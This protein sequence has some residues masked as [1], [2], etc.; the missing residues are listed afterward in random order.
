ML[1]YPK[2][3]REAAAA[4]AKKNMC[5]EKLSRQQL[6]CLVAYG[7]HGDLPES[8]YED[9]VAVCASNV[10]YFPPQKV[11]V[12]DLVLALKN[13]IKIPRKMMP[14][15]CLHKRS[16]L[17]TGD[18]EV[19]QALLASGAV[20]ESEVV[21]LVQRGCVSAVLALTCAPW[22][23]SRR[24]HLTRTEIETV[25]RAID[26]SLVNDMIPKL[27]ICSQD[28][29]ALADTVGIPPLNKALGEIDDA[30]TCARLVCDWP[31]LN[32]MKFLSA[33]MVRSKEFARAVRENAMALR[34]R[35]VG[36][37]R[38]VGI[39]KF[40][41][42]M[43]PEE[44]TNFHY[45]EDSAAANFCSAAR[46]FKT[47][48]SAKSCVPDES[49]E[50]D[51]E[52]CNSI[53]PL[54]RRQSL[55]SPR[56]SARSSASS[57]RARCAS[58][59]VT[60]TPLASAAG[61]TPKAKLASATDTAEELL[62]H[63][64]DEWAQG[65]RAKTAALEKMLADFRLN[66]TFART[67]LSSD[68][69]VEL[70]KKM[71]KV[72]CAWQTV[73]DFFSACTA[74]IE[75]STDQ[76][77]SLLLQNYRH[78]GAVMELLSKPPLPPGCGCEFCGRHMTSGR[79]ALRSAS[80][81]AGALA[82][83]ELDDAALLAAVFD[84][85]LLALHGVVDPSFA[86]SVAWGPLSCALEGS[87]RMDAARVTSALNYEQLIFANFSP[88][89][90]KNT[91]SLLRLSRVKVPDLAANASV[92]NPAHAHALIAVGCIA[93]YMLAAIFFRV[94][95]LRRLSKIREF[96]TKVVSVAMEATGTA[97]PTIKVHERVEKEVRECAEELSVPY[98]T[99]GLV[100]R[101]VFAILNSFV[102]NGGD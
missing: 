51:D 34:V 96:V 22:A 29:L 33:D 20:Y 54:A 68:A 67:M 32:V 58:L 98:C 5:A 35:P 90:V 10:M 50:S 77:L 84:M 39:S 79:A 13:N 78:V 37:D 38:L 80:F 28:L 74:S 52:L 23:A 31:Y 62:C 93:E 66:P 97:L 18:T 15:V 6:Q 36:A 4:L 47:S 53:G 71:L 61:C 101:T 26:P 21:D 75:C 81:G 102:S 87:R 65:R 72:V 49:A 69:P 1:L 57:Y 42:R 12:P 100:L 46:S 99:I 59:R 41:S 48:R 86:G 94:T 63:L 92:L 40:R 95:V 9:A 85:C 55:F 56:S 30:A 16:L 88:D 14:A 83:P 3:A 73:G 19:M 44:H 45:D 11:K 8:V 82:S 91:N 60:E 64:S 2:K 27:R 43:L 17:A 25:C 24:F 89:G 70:K 76:I 7:L